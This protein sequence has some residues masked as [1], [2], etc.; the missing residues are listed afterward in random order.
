MRLGEIIGLITG[1]E[2]RR[3]RDEAHDASQRAIRDIREVES[4]LVK[5]LRGVSEILKREPPRNGFDDPDH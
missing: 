5:S 1:E 2:T 3:A 4:E